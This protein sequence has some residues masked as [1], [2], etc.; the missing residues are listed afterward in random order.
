MDFGAIP[1]GPEARID[2]EP[3]CGNMG[4][5]LVLSYMQPSSRQ[6]RWKIKMPLDGK[7]FEDREK[8][9]FD[10]ARRYGGGLF[11]KTYLLHNQAYTENGV[12]KIAKELIAQSSLQP[13]LDMINGRFSVLKA[14]LHV[15]HA[16]SD[17]DKK[18]MR[19]SIDLMKFFIDEYIN[20]K[21]HMWRRGLYDFDMAIYDMGIT[22]DGEVMGWDTNTLQ[23]IPVNMNEE[24]K[25]KIEDNI[26][27]Q[28]I[29]DKTFI[30]CKLCE[31]GNFD[32]EMLKEI[33]GYFEKQAQRKL[34]FRQLDD[35]RPKTKKEREERA[36]AMDV[37]VAEE[38][39]IRHELANEGQEAPGAAANPAHA[40]NAGS[41]AELLKA[42]KEDGLFAS[43][44]NKA[45]GLELKNLA[46]E[47][48]IRI[49]KY[50]GIMVPVS[51]GSGNYCFSDM[52]R[53]SN[54]DFTKTCINAL[55]SIKYSLPIADIREFV[56]MAIISEIKK[57]FTVPEGKTIYH[58][59]EHDV[60]PVEQR[61]TIV[62]AINNRFYRDNKGAE[63]III[64]SEKQT[65]ADMIAEIRAKDAN[66][67][68]D[69]ALSEESHIQT[70]G[71]EN[72]KKIVF[73]TEK[74]EFIQLEGV[75]KALRALYED[76]PAQT[77]MQLFSVMAGGS[78]EGSL[79]IKSGVYVFD[80]PRIAPENISNMPN[81]NKALLA[82]LTAA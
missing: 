12:E 18:L 75:I 49:V 67:V 20:F 31:A 76:D 59:I 70:V 65:T 37:T 51:P 60:I 56:K 69:A 19:E 43:A 78:P 52:M 58:I 23:L 7:A 9:S 25:A 35:I 61:S 28:N 81:L 72:I 21:L 5:R 4:T 14:L 71:D 41:P 62:Q 74:V 38:T 32:E 50:A 26:E 57:E 55:Q 6:F 3:L 73:K 22:T 33:A 8:A 54:E 79:A 34:T 68:I 66:A 53:G 39:Y 45:N 2:L 64:L 13:L 77:L 27:Q 80:L 42:L 24:F 30:E 40:G 47:E 17:E 10:L 29:A 48:V 82:A 11:A 46:S 63:R 15:A 36:V 44:M 16:S 1:G